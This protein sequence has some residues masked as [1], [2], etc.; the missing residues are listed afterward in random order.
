MNE[1]IVI[2]YSSFGHC[3]AFLSIVTPISVLASSC[4]SQYYCIKQE[5]KYIT[6]APTRNA[7][8]NAT[9]IR[10]HI[11]ENVA[12]C[13][14]FCTLEERCKSINMRRKHGNTYECQLLA[15]NKFSHS[16]LMVSDEAF[17]HFYIPVSFCLTVIQVFTYVTIPSFSHSFLIFFFLYL[18]FFPNRFYD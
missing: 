5:L 14:K 1:Y 10:I 18:S 9:A 13:Q 8:L 7:S 3:S 15:L 16:H 4:N 11:V 17:T 6:M 12:S 2:V